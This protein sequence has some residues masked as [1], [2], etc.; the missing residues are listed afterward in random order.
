MPAGE[1]RAGGLV[2]PL[3][4][5]AGGRGVAEHDEAQRPPALRPRP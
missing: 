4:A 5:Q 1:Q 3:D 2:G